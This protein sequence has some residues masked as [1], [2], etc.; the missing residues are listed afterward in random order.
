M[1]SC[2]VTSEIIIRSLGITFPS[3]YRLPYYL[4]FLLIF[5]YPLLFSAKRHWFDHI[6]NHFLMMMFPVAAAGIL[7]GLI[8]AIRSG[9]AALKN[10]GTPW[11]WPLYPWSLFFMLVVGICFRSAVLCISFESKSG[12]L[13][14]FGPYML[15][16]IVLAISL[17]LL[18]SYQVEKKTALRI[19]GLVLPSIC[20]PLAL[21]WYSHPIYDL[22]IAKLTN[23]IGSPIWV[24]AMGLMA[25]YALAWWRKFDGGNW[26]TAASCFA[27][28]TSPATNELGL[29]EFGFWP[30]ATLSCVI[31]VIG[32]HRRDTYKLL[33]AC[34][35][36][37]IGTILYVS[38]HNPWWIATLVGIHIALMGILLI[39]SLFNDRLSK[40][41]N[42]IAAISMPTIGMIAVAATF[43]SIVEHHFV[44]IE[45]LLLTSLAFAANHQKFDLLL[46]YS[47]IFTT[48]LLVPQLLKYSSEYM[49]TG[50][51]GKLFQFLI[52]GISFFA[53][54]LF[55]SLLKSGLSKH[56]SN[57]FNSY[58]DELSARFVLKEKVP[59]TA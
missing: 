4:I 34:L 32:I 15:I 6:D 22:G 42:A 11:N 14:I 8:P 44:T 48:Y 37:S 33:T 51:Q 25:Y 1:C 58:W 53:V 10:N 17:L 7:I 57:R 19:S 41:L 23:A 50:D 52:L 18:E 40:Q 59:E 36:L 43:T 49:A 20:I 21:S 47:G 9:S 24:T 55:I 27:T 26:F 39:G 3:R 28:F 46:R 30:L 31:L 35:V 54:G 56:F 2:F 45:L 12:Y 16:P 29:S 5:G 38:M 13:S